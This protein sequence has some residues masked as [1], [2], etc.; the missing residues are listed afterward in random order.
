V[1]N[2]DANATD[3]STEATHTLG[4]QAAEVGAEVS[5]GHAR[6]TDAAEEHQLER[7]RE[8]GA[9]VEEHIEH[10][11]RGRARRVL[12]VGLGGATSDLALGVWRS[13]LRTIDLLAERGAWCRLRG[14]LPVG[15][16][17]TWLSL[18]SG[19]DAGQLG[20]Y[21]P[22]YRLNHSYLP[23]LAVD[24]RA[25]RDQ[26]L[27]DILG[28]A[29]KHVG[30]VGVPAT[31]PAPAVQGHVVG[32]SPMPDGA[33]ATFP[34]ALVQQV[35]AWLGD[36]A[37]TPVEPVGDDI[38]RLVQSAYIRAEQRF[39]LARRLLARDTYDCF[40]LVDDG[41]ATV[42]RALWASFDLAHPRYTPGH[43]FAGAIGAFYRFVDDQLF[44]LLEL[45]DDET[46]IVIVSPGGASALHGEL[47]L[48]EWLIAQGQLVLRSAPS[49]PLRL[50]QCDVDW[51]HTRAWAGDAGAIYLNIAGREPE[52]VV[53]NDQAEMTRARLAEQLRALR[54]P[55]GQPALDVYRPEALFSARQGVAPDLL[56][57]CVQ[58]GWRTTAD[59]GLGGVWRSARSADMDAAGD[60][61]EGFLI[62]YDPRSVGGGRKL[63]DAT[64]Y[65]IV[66]TLLT[67]L[68]QPIPAR[69]R[70]NIIPGL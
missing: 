51:E 1:S 32:D 64:I 54:A 20:I 13:E 59:V 12:F 38:D 3:I 35:A 61:A 9:P 26:R 65:D 19:L 43:P 14:G 15:N 10:G 24:S 55:N 45:V 58:P 8:V 53:P 39:M 16:T 50:D 47:A 22:S 56:V 69:L 34:P 37:L 25:M 57:A 30:L 4:K 5:S 36:A 67:L 63:D 7:A 66:P 18:F 23:P 52:G 27:W 21:G 62:V 49:G 17:A 2:T 70:G 60:T 42:Q 68:D 29:G 48:N 46:L 31:T 33:P 41:I 44:E 11:G 28:S 40:V 6:R